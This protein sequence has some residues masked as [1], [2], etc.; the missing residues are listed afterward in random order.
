MASGVGPPY[1]ASRS[2]S[3]LP[4]LTPMRMGMPAA[5][6]ASATRRTFSF[7]PMLPGLM[8]S[9]STPASAA[10][11]AS[12]QSKWMSATR[13][14]GLCSR[15]TR[16]VRAAFSVGTARRTRSQPAAARAFTWATVASASSVFVLHMLCTL[17]G[18]PPP[19]VR[20][21]T[22]IAFVICTAPPGRIS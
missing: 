2:F 21:P 16:R 9:L 13:G 15:M 5:R 12:R 7:G 11:R 19:M 17:T 4:P 22:R 10:R 14:T 18:A 6:Q 20:L 8:R 3:R 1:F